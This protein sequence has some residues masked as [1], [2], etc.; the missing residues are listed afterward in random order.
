M[1]HGR[2][3]IRAALVA[4]LTGLAATGARVF[5]GRVEPLAV[6]ECP[7][8][9]VR[10]SSET[11]REDLL[12]LLDNDAPREVQI[13][14]EG[15]ISAGGEDALDQIALEVETAL[16][17]DPTIDGLVDQL[18]YEGALLRRVPEGEFDHAVVTLT[19]SATYIVSRTDPGAFT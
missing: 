11:T 16:E 7:G 6:S 8:L 9:N 15:Y 13:L 2:Q 1:P 10:V 4:Q 18:A 17:A 5:A 19:Y 3:Q 14:V 12:T